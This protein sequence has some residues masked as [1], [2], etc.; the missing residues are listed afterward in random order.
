MW[1]VELK[2]KDSKT[3]V[4]PV[5]GVQNWYGKAADYWNVKD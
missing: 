2:G 5:G 4:N 3:V 1:D